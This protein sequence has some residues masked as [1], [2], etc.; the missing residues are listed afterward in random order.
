[1]FICCIWLINKSVSVSV[2]LNIFHCYYGLRLVCIVSATNFWPNLLKALSCMKQQLW[3]LCW[4][5]I[6]DFIYKV[7]MAKIN[8][9]LNHF[10]F[11]FF[12][13]ESVLLAC[14]LFAMLF[15]SGAQVVAP[16]FF[17]KVVDAALKSMSKSD[18]LLLICH[19]NR[20]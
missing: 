20:T 13:Q 5:Y 17:G 16:L 12:F 14:G 15:S 18:N 1:M 6:L 4:V 10:S 9:L 19:S 11:F 8:M 3:A 7:H 2:S